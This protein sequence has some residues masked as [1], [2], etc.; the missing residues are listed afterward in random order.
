[1]K[2][3][4]PYASA[5]FCLLCRPCTSSHCV[6]NVCFKFCATR[7][8]HQCLNFYIVTI[9]PKLPDS[10]LQ[11]FVHSSISKNPSQGIYA[12]L[13]ATLVNHCYK[14]PQSHS[15]HLL[16]SYTQSWKLQDRPKQML[17]GYVFTALLVSLPPFFMQSNI[18]D[19]F[20][21]VSPFVKKTSS[22]Q[23]SPSENIILKKGTP[24]FS[25]RLI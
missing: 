4:L 13:G 9:C 23:A 16:K 10:Q 24:A 2:T 6:Q 17:L 18:Q 20:W 12:G 8:L 5:F 22:L 21:N 1:M 14:F 15:P 25:Y 11:Y 7:S 3:P 19:P